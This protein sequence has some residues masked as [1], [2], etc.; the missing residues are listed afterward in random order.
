MFV[1]PM[2]DKKHFSIT[3]EDITKAYIGGN[4]KHSVNIQNNNKETA[5]FLSQ[6]NLIWKGEKGGK[7]K[8]IFEKKENIYVSSNE[9]VVVSFEFEFRNRGK[10]LLKHLLKTENFVSNK[11]HFFLVVDIFS[12]QTRTRNIYKKGKPVWLVELYLKNISSETIN[13]LDIFFENNIKKYIQKTLC[14][15][16]ESNWWYNK[17]DLPPGD[18]KQTM[19]IT[20]TNCSTIGPV[21]IEWKIDKTKGKLK[22]KE[23]LLKDKIGLIQN[24]FSLEILSLVFENTFQKENFCVFK[25]KPF[26][27]ICRLFNNTTEETKTAKFYQESSTAQPV[28]FLWNRIPPI[29]PGHWVDIRIE[30]FMTKRGIN[31]LENFFILFDNKKEF[32]DYYIDVLVL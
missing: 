27:I 31:R 25:N 4:L 8:P 5:L 15:G 24:K 26:K 6:W 23:F 17:K 13:I 29:I 2:F 3:E 7:Y 1:I 11:K 28:S 32:F 12:L 16:P 20:N 9:T 18:I 21:R 30:R 10:Y 14:I 22:T 19:F